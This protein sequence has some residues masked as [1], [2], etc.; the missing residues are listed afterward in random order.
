VALDASLTAMSIAANRRIFLVAHSRSFAT[1][2]SSGVE[3]SDKDSAVRA[4]SADI[5]P[6]G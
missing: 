6:N 1:G 3:S 5:A 4:A 2:V